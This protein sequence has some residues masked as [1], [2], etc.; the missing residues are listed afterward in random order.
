MIAVA[1]AAAGQSQ[2]ALLAREARTPQLRQLGREE[3]SCTLKLIMQLALARLSC[4]ALCEQRS[5]KR[6]IIALERTL[7]LL[8]LQ[9][10]RVPLRLQALQGSLPPRASAR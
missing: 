5:P 10:V 6:G 3:L 7:F 8:N 4:G 2:K 9:C 1:T